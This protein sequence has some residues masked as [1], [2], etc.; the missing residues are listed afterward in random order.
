VRADVGSVEL[1]GG[2]RR[3]CTRV[4]EERRVGEERRGTSEKRGASGMGAAR[5]GG[6]DDDRGREAIWKKTAKC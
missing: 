4:R 5:R 3:R 1:A 2:G 6:G